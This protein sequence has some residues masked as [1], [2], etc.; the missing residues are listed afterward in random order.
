MSQFETM[1]SAT[2]SSG[3]ALGALEKEIGFVPNIFAVMEAT[4]NVLTAFITLNTQFASGSLTAI[5][6]EI[7]QLAVSVENDCNYC[8]AGHTAFAQDAR[9]K[10][11]DLKALRSQAPLTDRK[12][13]ALRLF[14][15]TLARSRGKGC[16]TAL[17]AFLAAGYSKDQ[18]HEVILGVCTKMFSNIT[19]NLLQVPLDDQFAGF[20]WEQFGRPLSRGVC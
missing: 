18:A 19:S 5:E 12:L 17:S 4:P 20:S 16:E 3:A 7:V 10:L 8:V 6:R 14:A 2:K 1:N 13:Q 11:A 9:M 15:E